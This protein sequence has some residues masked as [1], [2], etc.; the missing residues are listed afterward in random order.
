MFIRVTK[1]GN[2]QCMQMVESV[3][4]RGMSRQRREQTSHLREADNPTA[5][6]VCLYELPSLRDAN[7]TESS[8]K[9]HRHRHLLE[10]DSPR[11]ELSAQ[12][13]WVSWLALLEPEKPWGSSAEYP[14]YLR[15]RSET[16]RPP[17]SFVCRRRH[18]PPG[19]GHRPNRHISER[20]WRS[21]QRNG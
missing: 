15:F 20:A 11:A 8:G 14:V 1:T 10:D 7:D 5:A 17:E 12:R 18:M 4:Y 21:P 9:S 16:A 2:R 6:E 3:R 13:P 19:T